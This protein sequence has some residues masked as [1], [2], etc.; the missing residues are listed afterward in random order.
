MTTTVRGFYAEDGQYISPERQD[1]MFEEA[2]RLQGSVGR[3]GPVKRGAPFTVGETPAQTF[4]IR[5]DQRRLDKL[6]DLCGE[7]GETISQVVRR[8]IDEAWNTREASR[9]PGSPSLAAA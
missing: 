6:V 4:S 5:F 8:L 2:E 7:R 3:P 9:T 1:E